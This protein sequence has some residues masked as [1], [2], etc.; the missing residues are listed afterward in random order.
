MR[1]WHIKTAVSLKQVKLPRV[2]GSEEERGIKAVN[3]E[4][5]ISVSC[6]ITALTS[7]R[8]RGVNF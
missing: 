6:L 3:M 1:L 4:D 2:R 5:R 8:K 7:T